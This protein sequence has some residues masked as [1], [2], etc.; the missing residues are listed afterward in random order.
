MCVIVFLRLRPTLTL[1]VVRKAVLGMMAMKRMTM[2]AASHMTAD[3]VHAINRNVAQY[4]EESEKACACP[5]LS[6]YNFP[7]VSAGTNR[8][9]AARPAFRERGGGL[10]EEPRRCGVTQRSSCVWRRFDLWISLRHRGFGHGEDVIGR[11][12][13]KG[14]NMSTQLIPLALASCYSVLAFRI[15]V[16]YDRSEFRITITA[17]F[18]PSRCVQVQ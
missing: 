14:V 7:T 12:G 13:K 16:H 9:G 1:H 18:A 11:E 15:R 17:R 3:E 10:V 2:G 5:W 8:L 4:K 6:V